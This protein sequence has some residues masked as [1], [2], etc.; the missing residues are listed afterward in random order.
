MDP[1][2][3]RSFLVRSSAGV[4]GAAAVGAGGIAAM[5]GAAG[6]AGAAPLTEEE[7]GALDE[8]VMVSVRDAAT[9]EVAILVGDREV[10]F[11]DKSLVANVLRATKE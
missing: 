9:G 7:L 6:A 8:T 2:S 11:T 4:A 5:A 10:T 3:R 1:V